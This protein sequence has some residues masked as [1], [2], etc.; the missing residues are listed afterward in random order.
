[1]SQRL[2]RM[3]AVERSQAAASSGKP[4]ERTLRVTVCGI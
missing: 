1:M 3:I 2:S 4:Q